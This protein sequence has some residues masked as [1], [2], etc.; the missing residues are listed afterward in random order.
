MCSVWSS[1]VIEAFPLCEFSLEIDV[2][3][4]LLTAVTVD[5]IALQEGADIDVGGRGNI[6]HGRKQN[7]DNGQ[8][9]SNRFQIRLTGLVEMCGPSPPSV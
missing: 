9:D 6:G 2:A 7:K 1:Q 8:V 5:A 3:L 4:G